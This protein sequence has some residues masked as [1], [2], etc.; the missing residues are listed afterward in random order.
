MSAKIA[1]QV[2]FLTASMFT[3][4]ITLAAY[5]LL[6]IFRWIVGHA[7][8]A[9]WLEDLLFGF[10]M[11]IPV[12]YVFYVYND[13]ALRWYG[14]LTLAAGAAA[15]E[16]GISSP[17]RRFLTKIFGKSLNDILNKCKEKMRRRH[18]NK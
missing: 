17:L 18:K 14:I 1:G 13:G 5:D 7:K 11:S 10:L 3:G 9:I 6:R 8:A 2:S 16:K 4:M 15:Y 12:F